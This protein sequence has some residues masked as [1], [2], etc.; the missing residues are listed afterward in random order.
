MVVAARLPCHGSGVAVRP[1]DPRPLHRQPRA[2]H[3]LAWTVALAM[4]AL[5]SAA[6]ALGTST[7][8]DNGTFRVFYLFGAILN[9][10]WLA[11][12]T[13]YL[14]RGATAGRRAQWGLVLFTRARGG[15]LLSAPMTAVARA[16]DPVGKDVSARSRGCS[17]RSAAA[18]APS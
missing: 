2:P 8:W 1:G 7:G 12:G 16:R 9:V 18:S 15:V 3:E 6:L 4:F 10:P 14:L 13:V 5:A 11:L 17:P